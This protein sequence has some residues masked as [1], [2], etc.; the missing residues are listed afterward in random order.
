MMGGTDAAGMSTAEQISAE[1]LQQQQQQQYMQQLQQQQQH[2]QQLQQQQQELQEAM[3]WEQLQRQSIEGLVN[4]QSEAMMQPGLGASMSMGGTIRDNGPKAGQVPAAFKTAS[5]QVKQARAPIIPTGFAAMRLQM[6]Q[7]L[8]A[9]QQVLQ[10]ASNGKPEKCK[11]YALG[12][13][14][15]GDD[16]PN[17]HE[18]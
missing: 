15:A 18:M 4:Q 6:P 12:A 10:G 7:E 16:C 2:M 5:F 14:W 13:C 9:M 11:W 8:A 1:Q 17:L 3:A